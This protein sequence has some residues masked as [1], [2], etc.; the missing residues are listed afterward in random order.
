[1]QILTNRRLEEHPNIPNL[2]WYDFVDVGDATFIPALIMERA[3]FGSLSTLLYSNQ[4][5]L[6]VPHRIHLCADV[7]TGLF[8][9]HEAGVVHGDVKSDNVLVF[10]SDHDGGYLAKIADFGSVIIVKEHDGSTRPWRYY[11]TPATN[12]PEVAGQTASKLSI[13]GLQKCDNYSL[14]LLILEV[15]LGHLDSVA[16]DKTAGVLDYALGLVLRAKLSDKSRTDIISALRQLLPYNPAL[17]CKDLSIIKHIF[18][19]LT[20]ESLSVGKYVLP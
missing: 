16:T 9:L 6:T 18:R 20:V 17:R 7:T 4:R 14:G 12:A 10:S 5:N 3:T 1:V 19:P 8:A 11:G 13:S 2:L 15:I